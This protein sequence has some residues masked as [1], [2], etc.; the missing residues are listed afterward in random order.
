MQTLVQ[1]SAFSVARADASDMRAC[2][3][4]L[5][6][7]FTPTNAPETL[8]ALDRSGGLIGAAAVGWEAVG[9]PAALPVAI[10]VIAPWRHHGVGRALIDSMAKLAGG[11]APALQPW[12]VLQEGSEAA[13]F[14]L[15]VGFTIDH[16]VL[17]FESEVEI[18]LRLM[19]SYHEK[20]QRAGWILTDAS[21]VALHAAP[22]GEVARLISTAFHASPTMMLARL[23]GETGTPFEPN[24][25]VVLLL[26]G[27]VVGAHMVTIADDG[28]P[29]IE[30]H[31][32]SLRLRGGLANALLLHEAARIAFEKGSGRYR[33]VCDERTTTVVGMARRIAPGP[34]RKDLALIRPV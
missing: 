24:R 10:H 2:R 9:D 20:L 25:S 19:A 33:F 4:L 12:T 7:T 22:A 29:T 5:P 15:A 23:R 1:T 26:G 28:I 6:H 32:V 14:C 18:G 11:E 30:A 13:A 31:V 8:V 21:I 16:H 3:M 17:H 27:R 34:V